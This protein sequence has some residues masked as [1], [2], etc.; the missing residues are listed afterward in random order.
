MLEE[1]GECEKIGEPKALNKSEEDAKNPP[2]AI[3]GNDFYGGNKNQAQQNKQPQTATAP[4][5]RT[6]S[7]SAH[8]NIY[9]IESIS[10]YSHKWTIKARCTHKSEIKTWHNRNGEGKLFSVNLLDESGEIRAT[11]FNDQCDQLYDLFQENSVYYI[12]TPCK[13]QIAKKQFSNLNNDW[14]LVFERD[15]R[16][17]KAEEQ[18]GVPQ[19]RFNFT[20][21]ADLQDVQKDSTVDVIG[22]LK[23]VA[24]TSQVVS[25]TTSK[26]Y[27]K[28]ELTLVDQTGFSVRLTIWGKTASGFDAPPDSVVAFKGVKVSD[29]GGRSLSLLSSGSL[30]VNPD[31]DE[32]HRLRGWYDAQGRSENFEN[33]AGLQGALAAGGGRPDNSKTIA[34]VKEEQLGMNDEA[35]FFTLRA[36]VVYI[37]TSSYS[38]P[39]CLSEK[40]NKKVIENEPGLWRCE[41]CNIDHPRPDHR[42][43]MSVNVSD[44]TGQ[45]WLSAFNEAGLV[46]MGRP[47]EE[48]VAVDNDTSGG[49]KRALHDI[50]YAATYKTWLFRCKGKMESMQGQQQYVLNF[51]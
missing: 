47:A 11:G 36:T 44:H 5:S 17:E 9:P 49:D 22:I 45:L 31:M 28:R 40:C 48:V 6:A 13:T 37:K 15:T 30:S 4:Y 33:H 8:A 35:D 12:S 7:S 26:P 21:I 38:Y 46:I 23:D 3:Q 14:E 43:V 50:F 1:L 39:A 32:S 27:D 2:S 10:L 29:F 19:V 41:R 20:G 24:E 42:Y 16:V 34:Q 51:L 25:K 18:D